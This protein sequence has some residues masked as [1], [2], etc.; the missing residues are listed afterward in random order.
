MM[1]WK[2][3][4]WV[5]RPPVTMEWKERASAP[6]SRK[7]PLRVVASLSLSVPEAVLT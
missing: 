4:C 3:R 6:L 2:K 7:L 5:A 1:S